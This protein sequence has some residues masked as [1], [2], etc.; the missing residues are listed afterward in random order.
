MGQSKPSASLQTTKSRGVVGTSDSHAAVEKDLD[1]L[2][3]SADRNFQKFNNGK[4]K[5]LHIG[6][7]N[8]VHQNRLWVNWLKSSVAERGVGTKRVKGLEHPSYEERSIE[9]ELSIELTQSTTYCT[10]SSDK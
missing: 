7:N 6:R 1:S 4:C 9:L 8:L 5:A 3:K 2:E 10:N